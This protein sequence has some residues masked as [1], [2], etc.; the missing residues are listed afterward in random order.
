MT[1]KLVFGIRSLSFA[2]FLAWFGGWIGWYWSIASRTLYLC[3]LPTVVIAITRA[4]CDTCGRPVNA[5]DWET[6]HQIG[7]EAWCGSCAREYEE[8]C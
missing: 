4:R 1:R 7:E 6:S 3:A 5:N 2:L 8:E